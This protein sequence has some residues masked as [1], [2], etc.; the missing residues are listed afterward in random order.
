MRPTVGTSITPESS[1]PPSSLICA[2][3][4]SKFGTP[5]YIDQN[6]GMFMPSGLCIRPATPTPPLRLNRVYGTGDPGNGS[7]VQPTT[8]S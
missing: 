2:T 6:G 5:M 8:E 4:C 7:D 3:A 1:V